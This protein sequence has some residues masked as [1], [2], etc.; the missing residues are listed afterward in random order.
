MVNNKQVSCSHAH[1][2]L[3]SLFD[4]Y[5]YTQTLLNYPFAKK[6]IKVCMIQADTVSGQY[7]NR[8]TPKATICILYAIYSVGSEM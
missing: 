6:V 8:L 1:C 7:Q 5:H 4:H 3:F 2:W